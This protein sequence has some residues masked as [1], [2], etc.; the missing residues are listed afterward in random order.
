MPVKVL[1]VCLGNICRS[2]AAEGAFTKL[3]QDEGLMDEFEIDSCGTG[4][5]HVG[6]LPHTT[7]RK[8]AKDYGIDLTHRARQFRGLPD[9]EYYDYILAMDH[10]NYGDVVA[11]ASPEEREKIFLFRDFEK[12]DSKN[13][14]GKGEAVPDPYYGGMNGFVLVQETV[15]KASTGLLNYIKNTGQLK[16]INKG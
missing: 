3:I 14:Y 1:F 10:S 7:T 16:G 9:I 6:E 11:Q 8:V 13:S 12:E 4:S 5:W 15:M 2:P